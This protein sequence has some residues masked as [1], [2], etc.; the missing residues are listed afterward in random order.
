MLISAVSLV[1]Q[2]ACLLVLVVFSMLKVNCYKLYCLIDNNI[3]HWT[4]LWK[5]ETNSY[6]R[7]GIFW[8]WCRFF[9]LDFLL[10]K[11]ASIWLCFWPLLVFSYQ[12]R[13]SLVYFILDINFTTNH[14]KLPVFLKQRFLRRKETN[15][16]VLAGRKRQQCAKKYGSCKK[17]IAE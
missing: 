4:H 13:S 14:I 9:L 5:F 10:P 17:I 8:K 7:W 1:F 2:N 6:L 11:I 3:E 16:P 12:T 15:L